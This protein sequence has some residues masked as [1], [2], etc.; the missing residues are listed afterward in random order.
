M[1]SLFH[2]LDIGKTHLESNLVLGPMAGYTDVAFRTLCIEQGASLTTT[3]MVS[4]E[5]LIRDSKNTFDLLKKAPNEKNLAIQLFGSKAD[6][7]AKAARLIDNK[8]YCAIDI[9]CG[10][11][12]LK[13]T[14][15]GAG[16]A[17]MQTPNIIGDL[18][19]ALKDNTDLPITIKIRLG[20]DHNSINFLECAEIAQKAGVSGIGLHTRTKSQLY[21]GVA[22][23]LRLK[24]LKQNS[25]VPI[26]GSGDIFSAEDAK[27]VLEETGVD[28]LMFAR[29][30]IGHCTVFSETKDLLTKGSYEKQ[31]TKQVIDT[32]LRQLELTAL[33]KGEDT[34]CREMRKSIGYYLKGIKNSAKVK[35]AI[36]SALTIDE[37]RGCLTTLL[38]DDSF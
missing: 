17:L 28:A 10:C 31:T 35:Q 8:E 3:E 20:W 29:G 25:S 18:V 2:P 24:E 36:C 11:P 32:L 34:A 14:R 6:S 1:S 33:D 13:V 27:R 30:S 19:K 12:V 26:I 38:I 15:T 22:D 37:Y 23:Y 21:T 7:F 5:G 9:N 16:S 4:A